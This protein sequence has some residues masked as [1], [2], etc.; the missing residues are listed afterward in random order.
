MAALTVKGVRAN[1]GQV[2]NI[3]LLCQIAKQMGANAEQMAG[4]HATMTQESTCVNLQGGDRDSAGLFQQRPSCG[5]GSYAQVTTPSYAIRKF[6]TPYLNYCHHGHGILDASNLVQGSAYPAAPARWLPESR[7]NVGTVLGSGDFSDVTG[8]G[9]GRV[10]GLTKTTTR[11]LPYEFSRGNA[12]QA[13]DSWTCI[14]RLADE[15]SWR[16]FMRDGVL[17]FASDKWLARQTP[18]FVFA[19]G[20]RGV[21]AITHS[22]DA[23]RS[24][25]EA[26]VT[27]LADR[28]SVRPGD[29]ATVTG[30]GPADGVW[31]VTDVQRSIYAATSTITL[32]RPTRPK[33][34]PA[35]QT[36]STSVNVGGMPS[37]RLGASQIGGGASAGPAKAQQFYNACQ[38]ISDRHLP[39]VWGGGHGRC[40]V[41]S[42][43]GFDC[44]GS[45]C[46][47]LG[48]AG[49]GY[50]LGGP[51]DTSGTMAGNWGSPGRGRWFTVWANFEHVW[52]Q[53]TGVGSA[54][55]FD[56]SPHNCGAD[57]AQLRHCPRSTAGFAPRHWPGL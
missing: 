38:T 27:A 55:R 9:M 15:V 54:W 28:W 30:Q 36:Q 48:A 41:A 14:G 53:F 32:K 31:L 40:G 26:S 4:A 44:S 56:T 49:L 10:P 52:V 46:A 43:G 3:V 22:E 29:V 13:E 17:W 35:N 45:V 25:A 8:L 20:A 24:A 47:A 34:E 5:W 19:E 6:L 37:L 7:R 33:I 16:R 50:R 11:I 18:R 23:R 39:Y 2:A 51:V 12:G 57:G 1:R 21:L 42:G